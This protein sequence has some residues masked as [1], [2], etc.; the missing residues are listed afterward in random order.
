MSASPTS[1]PIAS[2]ASAVDPPMCGVTMTLDRPS[3]GDLNPSLF[4][5]GSSG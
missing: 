1:R 5:S 2:C 3:S 4:F